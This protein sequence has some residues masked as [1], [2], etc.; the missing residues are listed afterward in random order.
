MVENFFFEIEH[1][2]GIL[3]ANRTYFLT[4]S[5]PPFLSSMVMAL[6][7][8]LPDPITKQFWLEKS[9]PFI[10]RD[11]DMW[12]H[13]RKARRQHRPVTVLRLRRGAGA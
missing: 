13:R 4:R 9:Y 10:Q 7:D 8:A 3:N 6:Y 12:T 5:Q 1:Y 2:G 11:Y